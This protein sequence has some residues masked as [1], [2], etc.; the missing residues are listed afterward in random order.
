MGCCEIRSSCSSFQLIGLRP[1]GV[2]FLGQIMTDVQ[3]WYLVFALF[4]LICGWAVIAGI[5]G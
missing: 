3:A 4:G 1:L 5:E 2:S